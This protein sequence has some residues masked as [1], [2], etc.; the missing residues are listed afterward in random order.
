MK[1][2]NFTEKT[3]MLKFGTKKAFFMYFLV[4]L[5]KKYC[6]IWNQHPQIYQIAKSCEKIQ[7]PKLRT[8]NALFEYFWD[9]ILKSCSHIW[10]QHPQI[11]QIAKFCEKTNMTKNGF[12]GYFWVEF[13]KGI[14]VFEISTLIFLKFQKFT[15]I[16]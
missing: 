10:N 4:G 16:A 2:A 9:R 5:L 14:V 12:F 3:K 11:C 13:L 1:F 6:H 8:K 7:I 15:K